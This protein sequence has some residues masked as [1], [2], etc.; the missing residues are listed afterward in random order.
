M[1]GGDRDREKKEQLILNFVDGA[2]RVYSASSGFP[3][4]DEDQQE[5]VY[6]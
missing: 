6:Q 1:G 5:A 2:R 4:L 3:G